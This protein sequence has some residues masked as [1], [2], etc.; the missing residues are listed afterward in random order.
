MTLQ[1]FHVPQFKV[2]RKEKPKPEAV[3]LVEVAGV[4]MTKSEATAVRAQCYPHSP[5]YFLLNPPKK[6][7][8]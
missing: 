7:E 5:E 3:D 2:D 1:E 8:S 4:W 6:D